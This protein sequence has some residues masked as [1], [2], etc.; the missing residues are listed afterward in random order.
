MLD[1]SGAAQVPFTVTNTR[2]QALRGRLLTK[3]HEPARP[4]WL[5]VIG[6]GVRDFAPSAAV[7]VVVQLRVPVGSPAGSYTFRLDAI[8][9]TAPDEDLTQGPSVAFDVAGPTR[10]RRVPWRWVVVVTVLI[11]ARRARR[12]NA[13]R[14]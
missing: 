14:G 13:P 9:E 5:S 11:G 1:Q 8:S 4:E 2:T 6:E 3:P 10:K 12:G 7:H